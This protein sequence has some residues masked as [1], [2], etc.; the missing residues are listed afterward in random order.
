MTDRIDR[1]VFWPVLCVVAISLVIFAINT[2]SDPNVTWDEAGQFWMSQG[3]GYGTPWNQ[4]DQGLLAGLEYGRAGNILDPIGFT[5]LL[6]G[7]VELFGAQPASLRTLPFMF[8][9]ATIVASYYLGRSL[10]R[11]PRTLSLVLP[12]A[13][14]TTYVSSQ[15]ATEIRNYSM[16]MFAVVLSTILMMRYLE[17]PS[18]LRI[19]SL[20]GILVIFSVTSRYSFSLAAAALTLTILLEM[21][22][23][24]RLTAHKSQLA[25]L[26]AVMFGTAIFLIWN[27]GLFRGEQVWSTYV[28][29]SIRMDSVTDFNSLRMLLQINFLYGWNKLTLLFLILGVVAFWWTRRLRKKGFQLNREFGLL[30]LLWRPLWLLVL[31]YEV[32][33]AIANQIGGPMWNAE[34]KHGIALISIAIISGLALS[35]LIRDFLTVPPQVQEGSRRLLRSRTSLL[36]M[37]SGLWMSLLSLTWLSF[38]HLTEFRR[39]QEETLAFTVPTSVASAVS[40]EEPIRWRIEA[41]LYPSLRYLMKKS[42]VPLGN[43]A[44]EDAVPFGTYGHDLDKFL[45][46]MKDSNLCMPGSTTAV[47][48]AESEE[49]N[50]SAFEQFTDYTLKEGCV[51]EVVPLSERESLLLVQGT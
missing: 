47:L 6:A 26:V 8:F 3:A 22:R 7:W 10:L 28:D 33:R 32:L 40:G 49:F 2:V 18:W 1:L 14:L 46:A 17:R 25:T 21:W 44:I 41:Q 50:R 11:L 16:E 45:Q 24:L 12:V 13:I 9:L 35:A 29:N 31:L 19:G 39:Y 4:P 38:N 20:T 36:V 30:E 51:T 27:I 34:H 42:E 48:A 37:Q 5:I 43:L 23:S 15:W